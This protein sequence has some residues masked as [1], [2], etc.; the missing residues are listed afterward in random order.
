MTAAAEA[1]GLRHLV[2]PDDASFVTPDSMPEAID[3]FCR[4]TDQPA[5]TTPGEYARTILDSL[6][7]KYRL[8][9]R[10]LEIV[11]GRPHHPDSRDRRR[12]EEPRAE[13]LYRRCHRPPRHRRPGRGDRRWETSACSSWP[14]ARVASLG[15]GARDHRPLVPDR[16][17]STPRD[18]DPWNRESA[19]FQQYCELAMPETISL[20]HL[21]DLW[22][23]ARSPISLDGNQLSLLRYRS[24]L[25]GAD[26]RIT[27]F[28]GGNTSS[29]ID[30]P[31]PFTGEPVRVLAVKGSGGDLGSIA[32]AGFAL[33]YLDRLEQLKARYRGESR[34]K[35]RWS[36]SIRPA[37]VRTEPGRG[38]DRY[39]AARVSFPPLTSTICTR[40]GPSRWPQRKRQTEARGIQPAVRPAHHLG[41]L[42]AA[43][44]RARAADRMRRSGT[45]RAA[46]G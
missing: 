19:R 25:L 3:R 2:D 21:E 22:D 37:G 33:L 32:D 9:I 30:L 24:N 17:C 1:P 5:P 11:T 26:L 18:P 16:T 34:S 15:G 45:T 29:K 41:A 44:L 39:A 10:D 42:A 46:M 38:I 13:P 31:D 6:A 20:H 35:T 27:N 23:D 12:I 43:R 28:G 8:V 36:A 40:T 4:R 7:L 14:R